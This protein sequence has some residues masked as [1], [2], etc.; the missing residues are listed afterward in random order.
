VPAATEAVSRAAPESDQQLISTAGG[1]QTVSIFGDKRITISCALRHTLVS[2]LG[3][4]I[5]CAMSLSFCIRVIDV[6][7]MALRRKP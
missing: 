2:L 4:D 5:P 1:S 7:E 6:D 3:R